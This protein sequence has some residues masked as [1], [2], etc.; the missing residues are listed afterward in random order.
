MLF[1]LRRSSSCP[2]SS[3]ILTLPREETSSTVLATTSSVSATA[4]RWMFS[5]RVWTALSALFAVLGERSKETGKM[6]LLFRMIRGEV[7]QILCFL[8]HKHIYG[9][10]FWD[11]ELA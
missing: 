3:S 11:M 9:L 4:P 8:P 10:Y 1:S 6:K 7:W 2:V 5:R